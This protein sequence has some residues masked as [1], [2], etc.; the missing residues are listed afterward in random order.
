MTL[1]HFQ[2]T[3]LYN[4]TFPILPTGRSETEQAEAFTAVVMQQIQN[5]DVGHHFVSHRY[6]VFAYAKDDAVISPH[7]WQIGNF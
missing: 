3:M 2:Q 6:K 4:T 1:H 5:T 7:L